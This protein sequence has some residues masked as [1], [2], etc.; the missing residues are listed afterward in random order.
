LPAARACVAGG[1]ELRISNT[2]N[3]AALMTS[4]PANTQPQT[5]IERRRVAPGTSI[6]PGTLWRC[7]SISD[8]FRASRMKDMR[9]S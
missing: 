7:R 2:S 5:G 4:N 9:K 6:N 8:F 3:T 1:A